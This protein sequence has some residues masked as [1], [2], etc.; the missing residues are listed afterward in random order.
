M[1]AYDTYQKWLSR[2]PDPHTRAELQRLLDAGDEKVLL[3]RFEGRLAFGT[4]GL[5]GLMGVGTQ[6]MNRLVVQETT[7][8]LA[9]YLL[10]TEEQAASKGVVVGF[11]GRHQSQQFAYDAACV[12]AAL[13]IRVHLFQ[14]VVPTPV[15]AFAVPFLKACAGVMIT[16]SHNPPQYNGYKVYASSGAQI[17]PPM[18]AGIAVAIEEASQQTIPYVVFEE[19]LKNNQIAYVSSHVWDTYFDSVQKL[20][21]SQ[22]Y[23]GAEKVRLA[24]TPLHGVGAYSAQKVLKNAGFQH[25]HVVAS[26]KEPDGA[27][28]T[29]A[30]PNPEEKGAMDEVL[31]LAKKR[32]AH[33]AFAN[34]PDADRLGVAVPTATGDWKMLSGDAVGVLMADFLMRHHPSPCTV[35][36]TVVSSRMLQAMASARGA[37]YYETLT[38]FKWIAN[39]AIAR[40]QKGL[41]DFVLGYEEALGY[42]VGSLVR[43]KDGISALVVCAALVAECMKQGITLEKRLEHL[44]RQYGLFITA[45]KT[46]VFESPF[47]SETNP[48]MQKLRTS[49]PQS[50]AGLSVVQTRDYLHQKIYN[51][52]GIIDFKDLP[53][54]DMLVFFLEEGSRVVVRPSGTE[55]KLKCYYEVC[56][57]ISDA[58]DFQEAHQRAFAR[59]KR[60]GDLHKVE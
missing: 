26:Q 42:T 6:R 56:E 41:P 20:L 25:V 59:L 37:S 49:L 11:D 2:D 32:D 3:E 27:F 40:A 18:D 24:Y 36:S 10:K 17:I 58:E 23:E 4:A 54:S 51:K 1:Q 46:L 34:D 12:L 15:T 31:H 28:P 53:V 22:A 47:S 13:G 33:V 29:V 43:D 8:G 19:A 14:Q 9:Q 55:P 5:R 60:L 21:P 38:G 50:I 45:Q 57:H 16:A 48:W 52:D 30:F 44:Y 39:Q 7:L 35:A